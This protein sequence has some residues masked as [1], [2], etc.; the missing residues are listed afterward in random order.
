MKKYQKTCDRYQQVSTSEA[1]EE[2]PQSEP[3][4]ERGKLE[5]SLKKRQRRPK[6]DCW[7]L[8]GSLT[9]P[10]PK[11]IGEV[12]L[13]E[14]DESLISRKSCPIITQST[15]TPGIMSE[16]K[17]FTS[18]KLEEGNKVDLPGSSSSGKEDQSTGLGDKARDSYVVD[19][20][21]EEPKP[22]KVLSDSDEADNYRDQYNDTEPWTKAQKTACS[23]GVEADS[24]T[25]SSE[26][27]PE[28]ESS[29]DY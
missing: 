25:A 8:Q 22:I 24:S 11:A 19:A 7:K 1:S 6:E 12:K 20:P 18:T 21:K 26:S 9:Y 14:S 15:K 2:N 17:L 16:E 29:S 5:A 10:K 27:S 28:D 4:F 13:S 3:L 23:K